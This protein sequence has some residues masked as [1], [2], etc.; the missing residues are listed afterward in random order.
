MSIGS[1]IYFKASSL[2]PNQLSQVREGQDAFTGVSATVPRFFVFFHSWLIGAE[3][4]REWLKRPR[5]KKG[6]CKNK[7]KSLHCVN[8]W[9]A[10]KGFYFVNNFVANE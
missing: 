6:L 3:E 5:G 9:V 4:R 7:G 8:R 2:S 1:K 10:R